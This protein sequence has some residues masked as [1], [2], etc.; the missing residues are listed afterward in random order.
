MRVREMSV[1]KSLSTHF[2]DFRSNSDV[3]Q[4]ELQTQAMDNWN[5]VWAAY[6]IY[7]QLR[8]YVVHIY[9]V[10][11]PDLLAMISMPRLRQEELNAFFEINL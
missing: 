1:P 11:K 8:R 5:E 10:H 9:N 7:I 3:W 2:W 6:G 4:S